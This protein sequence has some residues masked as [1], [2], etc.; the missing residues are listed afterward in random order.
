LP[1]VG[2]YTAAAVLSIAY[3]QPYAA[4]DGNVIRVL[5]RLA[6]LPRPDN[7]GEPHHTFATELLDRRRPG[8]WNQAVMELGETVCLP[9]TALCDRCP[10][11]RHCRAFAEG[12][13]HLYPSPKP[14]RKQ[15]KVDLAM[16][17]VRDRSGRLLLQRGEFPYLPHLWLPPIEVG[18]ASGKTSVAEFR[19]AILHRDFRVRLF[20][21]V[22]TPFALARR[23]RSEPGSR[24]FNA[25]Q[26]AKIGRSS[27]LTKALEHL[28]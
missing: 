14:R 16:T 19:H 11:R 27:L 23:A 12:R 24:I 17:I 28:S 4:V 7:K 22:L 2:A 9:K 15:E 10:L 6:C 8:D 18:A 13:V 21:R 25:G 3:D 5:S 20:S 1:G 26:L